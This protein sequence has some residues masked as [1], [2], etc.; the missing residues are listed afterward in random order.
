MSFMGRV[1]AL[2]FV[3]LSLLSL[4]EVQPV[5]EAQVSNTIN[6]PPVTEWQKT[7]SDSAS[8]NSGV[9]TVSN[10]IQT[11]DG[12]YAFID[13]GWQYQVSQAPV[14]IYKV[15]SSGKV[16]W[17]KTIAWFG[18]SA[19]A[20]TSDGG[21]E[22]SGAW[23]ITHHTYGKV[24]P[25]L[26]KLDSQGNIQWSRNYSTPPDLGV[27]SPEIQT[28][29]Y[30]IGQT[31]QSKQATTG[32]YHGL[33]EASRKAIQETSQNGKETSLIRQGQRGSRPT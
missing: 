6:S 2:L 20:E 3:T 29:V 22:V 27:Y 1:L 9:E 8:Y 4:A 16:Q 5:I 12:G 24:Q 21:Y 14:V 17:R 7:Y 15:D 10:L 30:P 28:G 25:T 33:M 32:L 19:I 11:S 23:E 26:L 31:E 13:L 18:A